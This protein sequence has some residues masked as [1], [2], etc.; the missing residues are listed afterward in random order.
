MSPSGWY[1][2]QEK[3]FKSVLN[4]KYPKCEVPAA[5]EFLQVEGRN[6]IRHRK[7]LVKFGGLSSLLS[8]IGTCR[9]QA[10][11]GLGLNSKVSTKISF[12]FPS[13]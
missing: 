1:H 12:S 8:K 7:G 13:V 5:T 6:S 11:P 9:G 2:D 4:V 3:D 10:E